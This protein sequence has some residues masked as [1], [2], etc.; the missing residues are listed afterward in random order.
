MNGPHNTP[1]ALGREP[2]TAVFWVIFAPFLFQV[3]VLAIV[4]SLWPGSY[5]EDMRAAWFGLCLAGILQFAALS[6][7]LEHQGAGPFAGEMRI[8]GD[9]LILSIILGPVILFVPQIV[10]GFMM[11]GQEN[12]QY[13]DEQQREAFSPANW[14]MTYVFFV[15]LLAPIVEEVTY[16]GVAIGAMLARGWSPAAAAVV[17]SGAFAIIH[18]QY[19]LA[20]MITIFCAGLGFAALRIVSGRLSVPIIAHCA[21][22]LAVV[23]LQWAYAPPVT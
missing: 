12:W 15:V 23:L 16:R 5:G 8:T 20:A 1:L 13:A 9:W 22:N 10:A 11:A 19:S 3:F 14:T 4:A 6:Y 2:M 17:S 21:A 18:L 7:W